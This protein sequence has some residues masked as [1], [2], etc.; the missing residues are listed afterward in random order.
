M[1]QLQDDSLLL[2]DN[3]AH[4]NMHSA[5]VKSL[6]ALKLNNSTGRHLRATIISQMHNNSTKRSDMKLLNNQ[7]R[8]SKL[9]WPVEGRRCKQQ[10]KKYGRKGC[11]WRGS[12]VFL[13]LPCT[14]MHKQRVALIQVAPTVWT[15]EEDKEYCLFVQVLQENGFRNN[16]RNGRCHCC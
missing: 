1:R 16:Q 6:G 4:F 9:K 3:I 14:V 8:D 2:L 11:I 13:H 12:M 10:C 7:M 15:P 5:R